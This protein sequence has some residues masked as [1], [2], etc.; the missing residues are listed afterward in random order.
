MRKALFTGAV[1]VAAILA[2]A[3]KRKPTLELH[4]CDWPANEEGL[5]RRRYRSLSHFFFHLR[6][7]LSA[8]KPT[9][10]IYIMRPVSPALRERILLVTAI[11]NDCFL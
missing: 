11:A 1:G 8:L 5:S 4:A 10:E 2:I 9:A 6:G 3:R 7:F